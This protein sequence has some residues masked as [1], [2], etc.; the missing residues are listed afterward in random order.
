MNRGIF[1]DPRGQGEHTLD[2]GSDGRFLSRIRNLFRKSNGHQL[3]EHILDAKD[4]GAIPPEE[5]SML[6]NILTW[7]RR[8]SRTS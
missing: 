6:L 7:A 4:E 5:V 3:A 2:E 8:R 1:Q